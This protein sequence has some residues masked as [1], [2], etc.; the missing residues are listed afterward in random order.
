MFSKKYL[1]GQE[2]SE[3]GY[4]TILRSV[5]VSGSRPV[6]Q[7]FKLGFTPGSMSDGYW[8][9]LLDPKK[10]IN[11]F[12]F[13]FRGYS[14]LAG[15]KPTI[16]GRDP[17]SIPNVHD[18]IKRSYGSNRIDD[19]SWK[20]LNEEAVAR[21]RKGGLDRVCKIMVNYA[22]G[23]VD[24]APGGGVV[25]YCLVQPKT[26]VVRAFVGPTEQLVGLGGDNVGVRPA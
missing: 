16:E 26:F 22:R 20:R 6:D 18:A 8:L 25:Q 21:L 17:A 19:D 3:R 10:P 1:V 7:E 13:E 5:L 14:H 4:I 2:V 11:T 23:N 24:Y 15:G 9:L 12:E